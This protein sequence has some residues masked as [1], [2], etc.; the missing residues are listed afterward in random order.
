MTVHLEHPPETTAPPKLS[1]PLLRHRIAALPRKGFWR[2][3]FFW[4]GGIG[5][6]GKLPRG[7]CVVVANHS[8]HADA[9]VLMAALGIG[10]APRVAAAHDYWFE[11]PFRRL[12]CTLLAAAFPV[13]RNESRGY[14]DLRAAAEPLLAAGHA[15]IV[16]P[17]GTRGDV[18]KFRQG[19]FK[20][21]ASAGVPVVPVALCDT[22]G[23]V[24]RRGFLRPR[25]V[26]VRIGEPMRAPTAEEARAAVVEL[27]AGYT[28][29]DSAF[30]GKVA[31]LA[32]TRRGLALVALWSFA[33]ALSWPLLPEMLLAAFCVAVPRIAPRLIFTAAV[34]SV[35][36][37]LVALLLY[38]GTNVSLPQPLTT[39]P[40]HAQVVREL[41]GEGAAAVVHQPA[42]G[43]PY[44]V[45]SAEAGRAGISAGAWAWESFL[46]RG[47]RMLV[48]GGIFT[49]IGLLAQRWRRFY[50]A[51]LVFITGT[52]AALIAHF[53]VDVWS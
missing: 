52:F 27:E 34:S 4:L 8:S 48:F 38:A 19:A 23:M 40:M 15:V 25:R 17:E 32:V 49:L 6:T 37:G 14:A 36:G 50:L 11:K 53:V 18:G 21:A 3:F 2:F 22:T 41:R 47:E 30:R 46:A 16:F 10:H 29:R 9:P 35:A 42:S 12:V 24:S 20:L 7:G 5:V 33:E 13:K 44:K 31:R 51:W 45:Y 26:G 1:R 43:I 28:V 39:Q